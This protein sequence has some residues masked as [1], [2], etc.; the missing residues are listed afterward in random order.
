MD[1]ICSRGQD[2]RDEGLQA[3]LKHLICDANAS[4]VLSGSERV[5]DDIFDIQVCPDLVQVGT[6]I[7]LLSVGE[8]DELHAR[9]RLVVVQ[10]VFA[11]AVGEEGVVLASQLLDHVAQREDQ[12]ED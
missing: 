7:V 5:L 12:P 4:R 2:S 3:A 11:G 8:H 9:G 1:H 6:H 10:F